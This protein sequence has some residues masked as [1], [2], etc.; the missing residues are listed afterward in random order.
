[1]MFLETAESPTY[2]LHFHGTAK[3]YPRL[4]TLPS[5]RVPGIAIIGIGDPVSAKLSAACEH[6]AREYRVFPNVHALLSFNGPLAFTL[7]LIDTRAVQYSLAQHLEALRKWGFRRV[8]LIG[9]EMGDADFIAALQMGF[10]DVWPSTLSHQAFSM[11][12]DRAWQA[13]LVQPSHT[14]QRQMTLGALTVKPESA[15]CD[16][17]GVRVF[18]GRVCFSLLQCLAAN[19]PGIATRQKLAAA[20]GRGAFDG[21]T[22]SRAIDMTVFR[23]RR[24]LEDAGIKSVRVGTVDQIGYQLL[25]DSLDFSQT[26]EPDVQM[27]SAR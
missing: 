16:V 18:L 12:V 27:R 20:I 25:L 2:G 5:A 8:A 6:P 24:K 4:S 21:H 7:V 13:S 15:S 22:K 10:D 3:H 17:Q 26:E 1:M 23:L 19:Y 9:P 14:G 11:V